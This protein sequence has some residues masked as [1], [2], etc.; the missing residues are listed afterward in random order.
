MGR[1]VATWLVEK[2]RDDLDRFDH[3][4]ME[5]SDLPSG[6]HPYCVLDSR[7][8][9]TDG[10]GTYHVGGRVQSLSGGRPVEDPG[11]KNYEPPPDGL[12][13]GIDHNH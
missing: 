7:V 8:D 10:I 11:R 9:S 6:S 4:Y 13:G 5:L 3:P 12:K 1:V 2:P